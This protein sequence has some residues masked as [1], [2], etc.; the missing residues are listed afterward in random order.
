MRK[1]RLAAYVATPLMALAVLG[2]VAA[3]ASPEGAATGGFNASMVVTNHPDS[4][5]QGNAWAQDAFTANLHLSTSVVVPNSN[6]P[7]IAS[8]TG[9]CHKFTGTITT[10]Q[11]HF[12][13]LIGQAV[14]G[15]GS[16]NGATNGPLSTISTAITGN[17]SGSLPYTFYANVP[18]SAFSAANAPASDDGSLPG[19]HPHFGTWP[20]QYAPAGTQFWD[21]SGN[22]AGAEYLGSGPFN[23]TYTAPLYNSVSRQGDQACPNVSSHWVDSSA[24][25]SN[26]GSLPGAG[27]ILAPDASD[28]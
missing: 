7:G 20:E 23:F 3:Q 2:G 18:L 9:A 19:P 25:T 15:T 11:G 5:S 22:T 16:L 4:G 27:N 14:P 12:T 17:M 10:S 28:C 8:F 24:P 13:T 1:A 21:I 6:C 26:S